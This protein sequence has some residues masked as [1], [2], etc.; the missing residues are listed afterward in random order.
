MIKPSEEIYEKRLKKLRL[1][2]L[3]IAIVFISGTLGYVVIEGWNILESFFMTLIT[4]STV[5]Y[6]IVRE[7]SPAGTIFT[8]ILIVAG[9]SVVL[10]ALSNLAAFI[11]EGEILE[12]YRRRKMMKDI[13]KLKDHH[14]VVGLGK[15]G[16]YVASE[17][18]RAGEPV[19]VIDESEETIQNFM[20]EEELARLLWVCGDATDE[21]VLA[22]ANVANART[23]VVTLPEDADNVFA[24]LTIKSLN[25]S[26]TTIATVNNPRNASK[27]LRAGADRVISPSEI[28]GGRIAAMLTRPGLVSFLDVINR[29]GKRQLRMEIVVVPEGSLLAG[30]TLAETAIPQKTGL[31]VIAIQKKGEEH[32]NPTKET[33]IEEGDALFVL[34]EPEQIEKLRSLVGGT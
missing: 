3:L 14:V 22:R 23:A 26:I 19:V 30:K 20:E 15:V 16:R 9:I 28:V 4:I 32:F 13:S 10:N 7:L 18:A 31:I 24:L 5:G 8:M 1:A 12:V 29:P 6:G 27:L 2:V 17:L 25:P 11:V 34:G 33:L 21:N